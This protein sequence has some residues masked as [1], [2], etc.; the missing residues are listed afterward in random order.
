MYMQDE[1][2][3]YIFKAFKLFRKCRICESIPN[4]AI[5]IVGI[6]LIFFILK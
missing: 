1:L 3:E 6:H 2:Y 4:L 5:V